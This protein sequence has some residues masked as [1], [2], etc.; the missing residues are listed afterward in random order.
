MSTEVKK[1]AEPIGLPN[2]DSKI[3]S[4]TLSYR[5]IFERPCG[6]SLVAVQ[7]VYAYRH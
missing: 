4:E 1:R 2:K 6:K 5:F 7:Y 3:G